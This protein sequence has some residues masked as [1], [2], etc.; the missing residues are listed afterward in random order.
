MIEAN[1]ESQRRSSYRLSIVFLERTC[2]AFV[3]RELNPIKLISKHIKRI[4]RA[5]GFCRTLRD[6]SKPWIVVETVCTNGQGFMTHY[7]LS[8]ASEECSVGGRVHRG[9]PLLAK[10]PFARFPTSHRGEQRIGYVS[11]FPLENRIQDVN[12]MWECELHYSFFLSFFFLLEIVLFLND[13]F[14]TREERWRC[15]VRE[16]SSRQDR[17]NFTEL[18]VSRRT[19]S[20]GVLARGSACNFTGNLITQLEENRY[21]G[22]TVYKI[23]KHGGIVSIPSKKIIRR[24]PLMSSPK[25]CKKRK[26]KKKTASRWIFLFSSCTKRAIV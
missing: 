6:E 9:P 3:A 26:K 21:V 10:H 1:V 2:R 13:F 7:D 15:Q 14:S 4:K 17:I 19:R 18:V 11:T 23:T 16:N 25:L 5:G 22:Q 8:L 24:L 12:R 20:P